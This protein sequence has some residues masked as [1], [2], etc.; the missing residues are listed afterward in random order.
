[1]QIN[2]AFDLPIAYSEC[3][4]VGV[5]V[6]VVAIIQRIPEAWPTATIEKRLP[7]GPS[8]TYRVPRTRSHLV[9]STP[10]N[11]TMHTACFFQSFFFFLFS[12]GSSNNNGT[13]CFNW[14]SSAKGGVGGRFSRVVSSLRFEGKRKEWPRADEACLVGEVGVTYIERN[15]IGLELA[16]L[17][18][19]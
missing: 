5:A 3:I 9:L 6:V 16:L 8:G 13:C 4:V 18:I 2:P 14:G 19:W 15:G 10:E 11:T 7:Q 1:M 12:L 17:T